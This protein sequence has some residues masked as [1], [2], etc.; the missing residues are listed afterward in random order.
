MSP[1]PT[2]SEPAASRRRPAAAARWL[3]LAHR[4]LGVAMGL[5][6]LVWFLSGIGML[7]IRW[8]E[9]TDAQRA[10]AQPPIAWAGCCAFGDTPGAVLVRR[11]VVEDLAGR[12]VLRWD[13]GVLDLATGQ[14]IHH[15]GADEAAAV[16]HAYAR[17]HGVSGAAG[18]P[19]R[20]TRDAWTVTGYY[21]AR[22]P[23]HVFAFDDP[24]RTQIYVSARTGAVAQVVNQRQKVLS[25]LGPIPHWLYVEALR[26]DTRLWTQVVIWSAILG[27]FLTATG[28]YLGV[29]A[30]TRRRADRW[31]PYRGWMA[32]HHLTGLFAGVLT[33]TWAASGVVSMNPWGFL[34]AAD[35]PHA[36]TL[37]GEVT[38]AEVRQAIEAAR[39]QGVVARRL[40]LAPLAGETALMAD[41]VRLG[42]D[43]RPAPLGSRDVAAAAAR[44]PGVRSVARIDRE[45]AYHYAHHAPVTLPAVRV[46]FDD[47]ARLYLDPA[48]GAVLADVGRARQAYR[49]LFEAPHRFDMIPGL[50][51]GSAAWASLMIGLLLAGG[52]GVA[53]GVWLG[54]RRV[55]R[56]AAAV[57]PRMTKAPKPG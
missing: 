33:L 55:R 54:V 8:P 16:A 46:I 49:W 42:V 38:F 23:F 6:M 13:E 29:V 35:T 47:R 17:A 25:W 27:V 56:D 32:W 48:S 3:V 12:P 24:A 26:A 1:T 34:E 7:F 31:T 5:L 4:Y 37:A 22:R 41:G 30:W 20:V 45:D 19:R 36:E 11:A 52:A 57:R 43:G 28:L 9:V 51:G 14:P 15:V 40:T 53:T 21:N 44:L 18:P 10:A 39:A 2:P 50:R